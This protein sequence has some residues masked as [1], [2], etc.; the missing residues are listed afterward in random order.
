MAL[1][2]VLQQRLA[3]LLPGR[4]AVQAFQPFV[5]HMH[6]MGELDVAEGNRSCSATHSTQEWQSWAQPLGETTLWRRVPDG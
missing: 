5:A 1:V 4:V 3:V 6:V 2:A